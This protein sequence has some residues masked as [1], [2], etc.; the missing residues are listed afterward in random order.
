MKEYSTCVPKGT[1]LLC[2]TGSFALAALQYTGGFTSSITAPPGAQEKLM[3]TETPLTKQ[4]IEDRRLGF[5]AGFVDGKGHDTCAEH[6]LAGRNVNKHA[7]PYCSYTERGEARAKE[8]I[9]MPTRTVTTPRIVKDDHYGCWRAVAGVLEWR[10]NASGRWQHQDM[11]EGGM[12]IN[13]A[14]VRLLADLLAN[15]TITV[16]EEID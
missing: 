5:L 10:G 3:K 8:L 16:E 1:L 9:P 4:R 12:F 6:I 2:S 11:D 15:P 7:H 14:R 13:A